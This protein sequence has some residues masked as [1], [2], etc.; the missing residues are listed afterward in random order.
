VVQLLG[1]VAGV[2]GVLWLTRGG[3]TRF[4]PGGPKWRA[5]ATPGTGG[6]SG[7]G[8]VVVLWCCGLVVLW[9]CGVV[10]LWW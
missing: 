4:G 3:R 9:C 2:A 1:L 6:S 5:L 7:L 10:V 8:I